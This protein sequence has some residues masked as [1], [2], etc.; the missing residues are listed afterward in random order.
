M[1]NPTDETACSRACILSYSDCVAT[2]CTKQHNAPICGIGVMLALLGA[3]SSALPPMAPLV[4]HIHSSTCQTRKVPYVDR[5]SAF[6]L[7]CIARYYGA[8]SKQPPALLYAALL[9]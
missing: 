4:N 9:L 5:K 6:G 2:P 8:P 7:K 3:D 1:R